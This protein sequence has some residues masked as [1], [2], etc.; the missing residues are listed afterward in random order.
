[1]C[2]AKRLAAEKDNPRAVV[3]KP[4]ALSSGVRGCRNEGGTA[5]NFLMSNFKLKGLINCLQFQWME[6]KSGN[7]C[8]YIINYSLFGETISRNC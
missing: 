3:L 6:N 2:A 7:N 4:R 1:M 8:S 5:N